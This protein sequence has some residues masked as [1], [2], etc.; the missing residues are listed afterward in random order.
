[1]G[2]FFITEA[3]KEIPAQVDPIFLVAKFLPY[4]A[5]Y[6]IDTGTSTDP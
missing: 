1:M 6:L 4:L 3:L 5:A 2:N